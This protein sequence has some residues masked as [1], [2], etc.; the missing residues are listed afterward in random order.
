[1]TYHEKRKQRRMKHISILFDFLKFVMNKERG[2]A[3]AEEI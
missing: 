2:N 1:M 3:D